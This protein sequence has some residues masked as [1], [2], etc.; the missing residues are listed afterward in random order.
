MSFHPQLDWS[1]SKWLDFL[2]NRHFKEVQLRLVNAEKVAKILELLTW[3]I[4]VITI[5]GTNGK[6]S[7]VA[8]LVAIYTAAS[9]RVGSFTS[10]HLLQFNER[11]C[12]NKKPIDDATLCEI[13]HQIE[14]ARGD[15]ELTYFE[16]SFL[17]ALLYFK[18]SSLD[19]LILEVGVG[20]RLD[21][22]NIIDSDL[23]II[24][25]IDIDHQDYLGNDK[26]TIGFEK[27]GIMR[28]YKT[29]IYADYFP[30]DSIK[31]HANKLNVNLICNGKDYL[32]KE[33]KDKLTIS[34]GEADFISI[35]TP[36]VNLQSVV[37]AIVA[38][39]YLSNILPVTDKH[40]FA[41]MSN[42][43][44]LG[45]LQ[46]VAGD[47][48][49]LY[50]VSHNPQAVKLLA[51]FIIKQK[52]KG[53]VHVI[54]SGLMDKDLVGMINPMSKIVDYWYPAILYGKRASS[55]NMLVD[56]LQLTTGKQYICYKN[57]M[58]AFNFAMQQAKYGDLIVV[59]GSFILVGDVMRNLTDECSY[60]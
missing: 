51:D 34:F 25:T 29:C 30:P 43:Q 47:I 28:P 24:T 44:L 22:T 59:Y 37:A 49:I 18:T 42:L 41:A 36:K 45:R 5:A 6:G 46:L 15:I 9:Y 38:S 32:Y 54:F 19:V 39:R 21:A 55:E 13:F 58:Q 20:G 50:D 26:E 11:I 16:T 14:K 53:S 27:A 7:T 3:D 52:I 48:N 35:P 31:K 8:S 4:P 40:L 33:C 17:A 60:V 2:E 1:L 10:P 12:V 23:A 57:P 56:A